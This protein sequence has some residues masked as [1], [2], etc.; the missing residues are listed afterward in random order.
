M[1]SFAGSAI[2]GVGI[3]YVSHF[4]EDLLD[5]CDEITVLRNGR[6]VECPT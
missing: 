4:L 3:V 1:C 5:V 6:N 2:L